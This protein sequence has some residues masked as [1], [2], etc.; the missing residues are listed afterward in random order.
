MPDGSAFIHDQECP[1]F[2][3]FACGGEFIGKAPVSGSSHSAVH[4]SNPSGK[5]GGDSVSDA[6]PGSYAPHGKTQTSDLAVLRAMAS[7]PSV[8]GRDFTRVPAR[9]F[10]DVGRPWGGAEAARCA[11]LGCGHKMLL[12]DEGGC[13]LAECSCHEGVVSTVQRRT[14]DDRADLGALPP[15]VVQLHATVTAAATGSTKTGARWQAQA[16]LGLGLVGR[17]FGST[18]DAAMLAAFREALATWDAGRRKGVRS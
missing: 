16:D 4:D 12:H 9:T 1:G 15:S 17:A 5:G 10:G 13:S 18:R 2:C 14:D 11:R 6:P 7:A 3:D 8:E